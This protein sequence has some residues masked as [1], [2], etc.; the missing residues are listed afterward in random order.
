MDSE[1][2]HQQLNFSCF[3]AYISAICGGGC[4]GEGSAR[5]TDCDDMVTSAVATYFHT[6]HPNQEN[7]K[8]QQII[9]QVTFLSHCSHCHIS[10][11]FLRVWFPNGTYMC[12]NRWPMHVPVAPHQPKTARGVHSVLKYAHNAASKG[13]GNVTGDHLALTIIG[14]RLYEP[15]SSDPTCLWWPKAQ[16]ARFS[17]MATNFIFK[18]YWLRLP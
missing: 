7:L 18:K 11:C 8:Q 3:P 1:D 4:G 10:G 16:P 15:R 12:S 14:H 17:N 2:E 9:H 5:G 13:K 6:Q